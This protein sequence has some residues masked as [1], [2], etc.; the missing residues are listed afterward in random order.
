MKALRL[1][2]IAL[3]LATLA[4]CGKQS[5]FAV[6]DEAAVFVDGESTI[7]F[8]KTGEPESESTSV[9]VTCNYDWVAY[10]NAEWLSVNPQSGKANTT[11]EV[12]IGVNQVN[13]GEIRFGQVNFF[14]KEMLTK[15]SVTIRQNGSYFIV[16]ET[17]LSAGF[18]DKSAVINI[19]ANTSWSLECLTDGFSSSVENG[20]GDAAV[21][22]NFS[23]NDGETAREGFVRISTQADLQV[24]Q[25]IVKISQD[26]GL[27]L[28]MLNWSW[29]NVQG[30][31]GAQ[32][33]AKIKYVGDDEDYAVPTAKGKRQVVDPLQYGDYK[34]VYVWGGWPD[35]SSNPGSYF[36]TSAGIRLN[37]GSSSSNPCAWIRLPAYDGYRP[38]RIDVTV[39]D[40]R[41]YKIAVPAADVANDPTAAAWSKFTAVGTEKKSSA[42]GT[43]LSWDIASK[44]ETDVEYYIVAKN[45][46]SVIEHIVMYYE[47]VAL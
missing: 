23:E 21:T 25:Y 13:D 34:P 42:K 32:E 38:I 31:S 39:Q 45:T 33:G 30:Y 44:S 19:R 35:D 11:V 15:T 20:D 28:K 17:E 4:A 46:Q 6:R 16:D 22:I 14:D 24:K 1:T 40:T 27:I 3:A 41:S 8:A 36:F 37:Y 9:Q 2:F 18:M 10:P 5:P 26:Y 29:T 12:T 7:Y 47:K 43:T